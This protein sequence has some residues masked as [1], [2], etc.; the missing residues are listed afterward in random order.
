MAKTVRC[1]SRSVNGMTEVSVP[2]LYLG[3]FQDGEVREIEDD[4]A[5]E[6]LTSPLFEEVKSAPAVVQKLKADTSSAVS[7][8]A[9]GGSV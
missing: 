8:Q 7:A 2:H 4:A 1:I 6:L 5:N 9:D 3:T